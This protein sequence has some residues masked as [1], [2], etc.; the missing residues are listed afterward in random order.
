MQYLETLLTLLEM[1]ALLIKEVEEGLNLTTVPNESFCS[2]GEKGV[3]RD[4]IFAT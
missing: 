1:L 2:Q 4:I 3:R